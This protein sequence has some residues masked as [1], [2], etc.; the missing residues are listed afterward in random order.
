MNFTLMYMIQF[1][2]VLVVSIIGVY[3]EAITKGLLSS[4]KETYDLALEMVLHEQSN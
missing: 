4:N 3:K 2:C 1:L